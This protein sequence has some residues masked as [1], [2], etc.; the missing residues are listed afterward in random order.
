MAFVG[1]PAFRI[2]VPYPAQM[3]QR[4]KRPSLLVS[5]KPSSLVCLQALLSAAESWE[6]PMK[7]VLAL[8]VSGITELLAPE[9]TSEGWALGGVLNNKQKWCDL[10]QA[11]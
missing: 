3:L 11:S 5:L 4:C 6:P 8:T 10:G 7:P 9:G 2:L 1:E